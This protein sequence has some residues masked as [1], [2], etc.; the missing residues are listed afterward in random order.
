[1]MLITSWPVVDIK[2]LWWFCNVVCA[3]RRQGYGYFL[4]DFSQSMNNPFEVEPVLPEDRNHILKSV[5]CLSALIYPY[6]WIV[7]YIYSYFCF[8]HSS[9]FFPDALGFLFFKKNLFYFH[10]KS[11]L[12]EVCWHWILFSLSEDDFISPLFRR[13]ISLDVEFTIDGFSFSTWNNV[14]QFPAGLHGFRWEIC[15][16]NWCSP[17]GNVLFFPGCIHNFVFVFSF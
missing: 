9:I 10:L 12:Q 16:S 2:F 15:H 1:M 8:I 13:I 5:L 11:I 4:K 7:Y 3:L 6:W 14:V 17:I